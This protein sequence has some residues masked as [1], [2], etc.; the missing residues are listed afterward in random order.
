MNTDLTIEPSDSTL[1]FDLNSLAEQYQNK[2]S[3]SPVGLTI[4]R[5]NNPDLIDSTNNSGKPLSSS[6]DKLLDSFFSK[7]FE[8]ATPTLTNNKNF[9]FDFNNL[10][11]N[12]LGPEGKQEEAEEDQQ[13]FDLNT[14]LA[15]RTQSINIDKK[16]Q[17][18]TT[19]NAGFSLN[20]LA[21]EYLT[22]NTPVST[23]SNLLGKTPKDGGKTE[24]QA[25]SLM[26][27]IGSEFTESV[28]NSSDFDLD[29]EMQKIDFSTEGL[30]INKKK[31]SA[32][33][34]DLSDRLSSSLTL[35]PNLLGNLNDKRRNSYHTEGLLNNASD[36][37]NC[38]RCPNAKLENFAFIE[39]EAQ[40]QSADELLLEVHRLNTQSLFGE[41][42]AC[43][44]CGMD[45][46]S[47][48]N[49]TNDLFEAQFA[50][51]N[52]KAFLKQRRANEKRR[53]ITVECLGRHERRLKYK[54]AK[55]NESPTGTAQVQQSAG[56]VHK[57][58]VSSR[59]SRR[60][61]GHKTKS[62]GG[63]RHTGRESPSKSRVLI[64]DF[65]IPSPDD[66]VIAKQKFA[67]KN[68]RFK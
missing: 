44:V 18:T 57:N 51:N 32:G 41:F 58:T 63:G 54:L 26:D 6:I 19:G 31:L 17:T 64:F 40:A 7:N 67:F 8:E 50:F 2:K 4:L 21:N 28:G 52:Q 38:R 65:S 35:K 29:S 30:L 53:R 3:I 42:L 5:R 9:D 56:R 34:E 33:N 23:T 60:E 61:G 47:V 22:S 49:V 68:M 46:L 59:G 14:I 25:T 20:D 48:V 15:Q 45:Q 55:E 13:E 36:K 16:P 11:D 62:G 66:I 24:S 12:T 1:D 43:K 10:M 37:I 39:C 27:L